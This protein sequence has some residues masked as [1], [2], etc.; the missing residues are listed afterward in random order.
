MLEF[1]VSYLKKVYLIKHNGLF[2]D[3][4]MPVNSSFNNNEEVICIVTVIILI[5]MMIYNE[6]LFQKGAWVKLVLVSHLINVPR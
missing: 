6:G 3:N 5:L 4:V 1:H 2:T